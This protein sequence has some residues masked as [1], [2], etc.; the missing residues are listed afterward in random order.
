MNNTIKLVALLCV[1]IHV[2]ANAQ[3]SSVTRAIPDLQISIKRGC[4]LVG[5]PQQNSNG[6]YEEMWAKIQCGDVTQKHVFVDDGIALGSLK[7]VNRIHDEPVIFS[8]VTN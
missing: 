5:L 6:D 1:S 2:G 3:Q 4:S 7:L 8:R